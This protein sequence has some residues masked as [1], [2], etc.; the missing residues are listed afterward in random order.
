MP[1]ISGPVIAD[2]LMFV[3]LVH[4]R[5]LVAID[6]ATGKERWSRP[7]AARLEYPPTIYRGLAY[8]GGNDG[9]VS[10]LRASDGALVWQFLAAPTR[11]RIAIASQTESAWPVPG[12]AILRDRLYATAGR[13]NQLD[14][15]IHA[16]CLDPATG[17]ILGHSLIDGRTHSQAPKDRPPTR[18]FQGRSNDILTVDRHGRA[19]HM[20]DIAIDPQT[21]QWLHLCTFD[22]RVVAKGR[23]GK[24]EN[25][26]SD[27]EYAGFKET[28]LR[29]LNTRP[30]EVHDALYRPCRLRYGS[31]GLGI[32]EEWIDFSRKVDG[33]D[34]AVGRD[35]LVNIDRLGLLSIS[36]EPGGAPVLPPQGASKEELARQRPL[37]TKEFRAFTSV[38]M[39]PDRIVLTMPRVGN[40]NKPAALRLMAAD[41]EVLA[42]TELP[43]DPLRGCLAVA[44]KDIFLGLADG[45]ILRF[46][47]ADTAGAKSR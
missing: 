31:A 44:G 21:M 41:G 1:G 39:T 20:R 46:S 27:E 30:L 19:V 42:E 12:V 18:N 6:L 3:S 8:I 40:A 14:G 32:K 28:E 35:R 29:I 23:I 47:T 45:R 24:I 9:T 7:L 4:H 2:G 36:L 13:H 17:K 16:W 25:A 11:R 15:G 38:A 5:R 33:G 10:C 22:R 26:D 34:M 43:A 37:L